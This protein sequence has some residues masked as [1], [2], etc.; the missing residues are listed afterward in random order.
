MLKETETDSDRDRLVLLTQ[1]LTSMLNSL[2]VKL[3]FK[4]AVL[5]GE[6]LKFE[7]VKEISFCSEGG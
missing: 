4:S 1:E 5:T 6:E 3:V 7:H 2:N